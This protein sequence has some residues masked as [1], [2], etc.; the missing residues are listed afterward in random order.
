MIVKIFKTIGSR[1]YLISLI[2]V[3]FAVFFSFLYVGGMN[4]PSIYWTEIFWNIGLIV[5][6]MWLITAQE[7]KIKGRKFDGI[8]LI[9]FPV[10]FL[11]S[12]FPFQLEAFPAIL[13][14]LLIY[15]QF[16]FIQSLHSKNSEKGILDLSLIISISIQFNIIFAVFFFLPVMVILLKGLKDN[17]HLMA[18]LLPIALISFIFRAIINVFPSIMSDLTT[19]SVQW[20]ILS[21]QALSIEE[22]VWLALLIISGL[23]CI[24]RFPRRSRKF[25]FPELY[26]G[27]LYM[28]FWL[29]FSMAY[30]VLVLKSGEGPWFF[31]FI[32]VAYFFGVLL[33]NISSDFMKNT[34]LTFLFFGIILF[35]L[36]LP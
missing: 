5:L 19:P 23:I 30:E 8:H 33:E 24:F 7:I 2:L 6:S 18:L 10:I 12:P 11:F 3:I 35:K 16:A 13:L 28:T 20:D 15:G 25:A 1:T 4:W 21:V 31:S 32:P 34:L 14:L 36:F 26:S 22:R 27:F 9:A 17:K 29:F